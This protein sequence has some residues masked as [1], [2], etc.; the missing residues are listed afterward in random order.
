MIHIVTFQ[1]THLMLSLTCRGG[2][3]WP[4]GR[5]RP[6][7]KSPKLWRPQPDT[8]LP[9]WP[10]SELLPSKGF[11]ARWR[12]RSRA[13]CWLWSRWSCRSSRVKSRKLQERCRHLLGTVPTWEQ[14][15]DCPRQR[16]FPAC[17]RHLAFHGHPSQSL[18]RL[19][20]LIPFIR[21]RSSS[22]APNLQAL[23]RP[24][25]RSRSL[26]NIPTRGS[27]LCRVYAT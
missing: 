27:G 21:R 26:R 15:W 18:R 16:Q 24:W 7:T 19:R 8:S 22:L 23:W 5:R 9:S 4:L 11:L 10:T 1:P 20:F 14:L 3:K 17:E 6:D 12:E 2:W 25:I 13:R